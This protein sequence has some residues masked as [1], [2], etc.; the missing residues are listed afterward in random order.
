MIRRKRNQRNL[1][2]IYVIIAQITINSSNTNTRWVMRKYYLIRSRLY[3]P[4][5]LMVA[6]LGLDWMRGHNIG[7][8]HKLNK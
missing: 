7:E 2:G 8:Q 6:V 4:W 3:C 1:I 5:V